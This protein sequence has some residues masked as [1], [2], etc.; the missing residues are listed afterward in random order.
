M[1]V[2]LIGV[3]QET[4]VGVV[5]DVPLHE[6]QEIAAEVVPVLVAKRGSDRSPSPLH[7]AC[8]PGRV[9]G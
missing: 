8:P 9:S 5:D 4:A 6:G 1:L 2:P 3:A 7:D